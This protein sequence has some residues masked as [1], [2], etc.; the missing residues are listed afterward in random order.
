MGLINFYQTLVRNI[1]KSGNLTTLKIFLNVVKL[2]DL[3]M[4]LTLRVW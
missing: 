2:P 1:N 4:F 3:F